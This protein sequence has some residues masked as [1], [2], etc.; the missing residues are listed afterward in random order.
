[1][2]DIEYAQVR[3]IGELRTFRICRKNEIFKVSFVYSAS[4]NLF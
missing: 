1:M 4:K 2:N 3:I